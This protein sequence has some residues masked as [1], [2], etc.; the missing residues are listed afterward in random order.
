MR[1]Y[2]VRHGESEGNRQLLL[3]GRTDCPLTEEGRADARAAAEKLRGLD[4]GRCYASPLSRAAD[5]ARACADALGLPVFFRDDLMEQDMG[6]FENT[7]FSEMS[8]KFPGLIPA[9]F[10]NWTTSEP[11]GGESYAALRARTLRALAEI[12]AGTGDAL[13]VS[14][15]GPLSVIIGSLLGAEGGGVGKFWFMHGCYSCIDLKDG[16]PR[17]VCFNR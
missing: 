5:T 3:Y 12:T 1:L 4:I 16:R 9:I 7:S 10:D 2:L 11:P 17:L 8:K 6:D 13:I 15:N 14:H